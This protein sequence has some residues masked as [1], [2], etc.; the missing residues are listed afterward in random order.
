MLGCHEFC[1]YYEWTFHYVRRQW[2]LQA[3]ARLWAEAIGRDSQRHYAD[4]GRESGLRGLYRTWVKTGEDE[5]CDWTFTLDEGRNILRWDMRQCPSKGFLIKHD[6][7]ADEDYCDHCMGWMVPLLNEIGVEVREHEHNHLGQCWGTMKMRDLPSGDLSV[8]HDIRLDERWRQGYLD[9]WEHDV[10]LPMFPEF[11]GAL[12][13]C[14]LLERWFADAGEL[15]VIAR[16]PDRARPSGSCGVHGGLMTAQV[17]AACSDLGLTPLA[18]LLGGDPAALKDAAARY[19]EMPLRQRPLLLYPYFPRSGMFDGIGHGLPRPVPLLPM[20]IR[21]GCYEHRPGEC[22]PSDED[23]LI[24]LARVLGKPLA[25][26]SGAV[27]D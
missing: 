24:A 21:R 11:A 17:F 5:V 12:D 18:V 10:R 8:P 7:N 25:V 15:R 20:L 27:R 22:P 26:D 9:R 6:L 2:G 19:R 16:L 1:G 4:A 14:E 3:V 23:L 13:S